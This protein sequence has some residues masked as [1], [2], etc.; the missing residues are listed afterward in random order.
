MCGLSPYL[1]EISQQSRK[2]G[3]EKDAVPM[4]QIRKRTLF[5]FVTLLK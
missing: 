4:C 3:K 2:S 5:L 1:P